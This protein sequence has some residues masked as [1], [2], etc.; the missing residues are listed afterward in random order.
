MKTHL[1]TLLTFLLITV[2]SSLVAQD[3]IKFE[4]ANRKVGF[5]DKNGN[6]AI[7]PKYDKASKFND[8]FAWVELNRK[9]GFVD[10]TGKE[11]TPLKYNEVGHFNYGF[12]WVELNGKMGFIDK[13]GKEIT[14]LKYRNTG[15][16]N[17]S[18]IGLAPVAEEINQK[19]ELKWGFIDKTGKEITP[20]KYDHVSEVPSQEIIHVCVGCKWNNG[21][22][23]G[24]TWGF[25]DKLGNEVIPIVYDQVGYLSE[26]GL[27]LVK[28]DN[29]W[30]YVDKTNNDMIA[31]KFDMAE[32]FFQ[33]KAKVTLGDR[34]FYIDKT[35]KEIE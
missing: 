32:N 12:A 24:G 23:K 21:F 8:G 1:K 2:M 14:P 31:L 13:T 10:K 33:G 11:I 26:E 30:G 35:G 25:I 34:T 29:L 18:G 28:R 6:V 15:N 9:K 19:G 17:F 7:V 20:L 4:G 3:L 22:Y 16:L 5:K 27:V